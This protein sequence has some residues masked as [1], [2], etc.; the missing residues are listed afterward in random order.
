MFY[1]A[2]KDDKKVDCW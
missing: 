1:L 2:S